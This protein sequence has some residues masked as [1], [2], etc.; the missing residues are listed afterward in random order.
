[1]RSRRTTWIACLSAVAALLL[2]VAPQ[3]R[4]EPDEALVKCVEGGGIYHDDGRCEGGSNA[5]PA[6][7][8][9][10]PA[11]DDDGD[12]SAAPSAEASEEAEK[13]ECRKRGGRWRDGVC[14]LPKDPVDRCKAVGG[15]FMVDGKCFKPGR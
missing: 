13:K 7:A 12:A 10:E 15:M 14:R 11:V 4:A 9:G 8:E 1:M 5:D 6:P 2:I 3:A